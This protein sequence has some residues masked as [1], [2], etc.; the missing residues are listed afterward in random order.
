MDT[1]IVLLMY[2]LLL[3]LIMTYYIFQL[4]PFALL[5]RYLN[6]VMIRL[7]YCIRLE[8]ATRA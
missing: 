4:S 1:F 8:I 5:Q 2:F 7:L 3:Y 6:V